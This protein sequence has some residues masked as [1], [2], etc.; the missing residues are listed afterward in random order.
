MPAANTHRRATLAAAG[1]LY[2]LVFAA[3]VIVPVH[4]IGVANFFYVPVALVALATGPSRGALAGALGAGLYCLGVVLNPGISSAEVV[5][6]GTLVRLCTYAGTG[7]LIGWFARD[8]RRLVDELRLLAERD[9]ITGLP[10]TRAFEGAIQRRLDSGEPF[11]L[12]IG[13]L[14][15]LEPRHDEDEAVAA[16][17][18]LRTLADLLG[19]TLGAGDDIA[20]VGEREF[21]VLSRLESSV[22]A[23]RLARTLEETLAPNGLSIRFGWAV[24]PL[25]GQN[26]L[27]LYRAADERLYARKLLSGAVPR[28]TA[29]RS[30]G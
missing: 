7:A 10:N 17:D 26:A 22:E 20:R 2:A 30:V 16:H 6:I 29:L 21:A 24:F 28:S 23:A 18:A 12:L 3:F 15:A 19:N 11:G 14:A 27:S 9:T 8:N 13:D 4:D 5:T 1:A 25:E